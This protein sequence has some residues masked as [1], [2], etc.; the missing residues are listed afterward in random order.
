M[1]SLF[2]RL[3]ENDRG[4]ALALVGASLLLLMG[5]AAFGSDLAW[6]YLNSSRIQRAADAAALGGVIW[7]PSDEASA[8]VNA[9]SIAVQNGYTDGINSIVV[10]ETD[11]DDTVLGVTEL[12]VTISADVPTFFL[13]AF[14]WDTQRIVETGTAEYV[15]TLPM[16]SPENQFGDSPGCWDGGPPPQGP[17]NNF[18]ASIQGHRNGQGW[19]DYFSSLC[20][21]WQTC[22]TQTNPDYRSRGYLYGIDVPAGTSSFTV[23]LLNPAFRPEAGG[24]TNPMEERFIQGSGWSNSVGA[25]NVT[26]TLYEQTST[27]LVLTS[28]TPVG[29]SCTQTYGPSAWPGN[30]GVTWQTHC[31]VNSPDA[32]IYPLQVQIPAS[33]TRGHARFSI[34]ATAPG[35]DPAVFALGDMSIYTATEGVTEFFLAEVESYHAGKTLVIELWDAGDAG[36]TPELRVLGPGGSSYDCEFSSTRPGESTPT[37]LSPC[38]KVTSFGGNTNDSCSNCYNNHWITFEIELPITYTC[39]DCWWKMRYSYPA[40][41]SVTDTTTWRAFMKGNPIHL[42]PNE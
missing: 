32:G 18:W 33:A 35:P 9:Q 31:T 36:G 26:F 42:V 6:F 24:G 22:T 13:K 11:T 20:A 19:G 28:T 39:S 40:G 2:I 10:A 27:P 34:R 14:G 21:S 12:R 30:N 29:G 8:K 5:M 23:E 3:S 7:L 16:G 37:N 15:P 17:C 1:R 38:A 25:P 4:A 41:F